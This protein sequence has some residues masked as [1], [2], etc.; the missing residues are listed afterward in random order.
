MVWYSTLRN[1]REIFSRY[2]VKSSIRSSYDAS[3]HTSAPR[4]CPCL[5]GVAL[6]AG[7]LNTPGVEGGREQRLEGRARRRAAEVLEGQRRLQMP[8]S[9]HLSLSRQWPEFLAD[10][11]G[12]DLINRKYPATPVVSP[13]PPRKFRFSVYRSSRGMS[14]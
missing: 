10:S 13:L 9:D 8:V 4:H 14:V 1:F 11:R 5:L 3:R 6:P 12:T 7:E 2:V